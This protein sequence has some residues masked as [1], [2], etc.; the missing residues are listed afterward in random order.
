[1]NDLK[2]EIGDILYF[3][4]E[5]WFND[6]VRIEFEEWE[7]VKR[8]NCGY[9]LTQKHN[10]WIFYPDSF[11]KKWIKFNNK[12]FRKTKEEALRSFN[13]R[14]RKQMSILKSKLE[15]CEKYLKFSENDLEYV[16]TH[17]NEIPIYS[18]LTF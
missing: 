12:K 6:R 3:C 9:T 7:V 14:K 11:P 18:G 2:C 16:E 17:N 13:Y 1:M 8:T 10:S 4:R 15:K 5:N